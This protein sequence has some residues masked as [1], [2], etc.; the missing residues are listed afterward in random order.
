VDHPYRNGIAL[1]GDAAA[2][3]D[4]SWGQGLSLTLCDARVLRDALLADDDWE[5]AGHAYGDEHDRYF[6]VV[7][8]VEDWLTQFFYETSP[9]AHA[10][11]ARAF[12]L[13]AQDPTRVPDTLM[14]GPEMTVVNEETRRRL[15]GED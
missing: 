8:M 10:R 1:I 14:S 4:P 11:R 6:G 7:H 5:A 2:S 13:I 12:P 9:E 15:F 3:S